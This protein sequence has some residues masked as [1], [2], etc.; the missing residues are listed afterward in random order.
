MISPESKKSIKEQIVREIS[1]RRRVRSS[2]RRQIIKGLETKL[3]KDTMSGKR[4]KKNKWNPKGLP[5]EY[6]MPPKGKL[7]MEVELAWLKFLE[8]GQPLSREIISVLSQKSAPKKFGEKLK[9]Y[10]AK[11]YI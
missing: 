7:R 3:A 1:E 8:D 2:R 10:K 11:G 9:L 6:P 4:G 5:G